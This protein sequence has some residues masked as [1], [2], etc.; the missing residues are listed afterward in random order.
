[1]CGAVILHSGRPTR[2]GLGET[3]LADYQLWRQA[4]R[5]IDRWMDQWQ[6]PIGLMI[7]EVAIARLVI[8]RCR[9]RGWRVP[10][11]VA[12]VAGYNEESQ[13]VK[14]EPSI[15]SM[16]F[17]DEMV[18]YEAAR[19]LDQCMQ[20]RQ[21]IKSLQEWKQH[22]RSASRRIL[23]PPVGIVARQS[24]DFHAVEDKLVRKALGF[25]DTHLDEPIH[26]EDIA[27]HV[28]VSRA[29]LMNRFRDKLGRTIGKEMQRLRV[30]RIKR[31]LVTSDKPIYSIALD[32]G[33]SSVRTLNDLFRKVAGCTPRE[34][35][36]GGAAIGHT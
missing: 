5:E 36:K 26:I 10:E 9:Q 15:T 16:E 13:C 34:Y 18:G 17:P 31:E 2:M 30:E 28:G 14:P 27:E 21:R 20:Q 11:D 24:T 23:L 32:A 6:L 8:E 3:D 7:H 19:L 4:I 25:I 29:T 35:R 22:T 1:M 33:F 12:L